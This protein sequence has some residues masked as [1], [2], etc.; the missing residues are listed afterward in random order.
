MSEMLLLFLI[1][2]CYPDQ[3]RVTNLE[4]EEVYFVISGFGIIHSGEGDFEISEGDI[5]FFEKGEVY[6]VEGNYLLL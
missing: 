6:W 2:S 5:Y 4:C 3:K 1:N